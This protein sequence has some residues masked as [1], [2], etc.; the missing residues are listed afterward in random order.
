MKP[1]VIGTRGSA[2]ARWQAEHVAEQLR[3]RHDG[4]HVELCII[5]TRGDNVLDVPLARVGGKGLFVKEIEQALLAG[6][7][8][9]AVHSVKDLPTEGVEG[10]ELSAIERREDPRDVLV[11]RSGLLAELP[12]HARV[13]TSSLRRRCQLLHIRSDLVIR[14]LRGNVNTRLRK[15]DEGLFD[16]VVL[17]AAGLLRLKRADQITEFLEPERMIPA[18]GQGALG[19][20]TRSDDKEIHQ[21]VAD[22][23]HE[24]TAVRVRAERALL[25]RLGGGCQVPIAGHARI[26]GQSL[27]LDGLVGHPAGSPVYRHRAR[28]EA[29][30]PEA[31]GEAVAEHLL[32]QGG[33]RILADVYG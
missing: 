21:T 23:H 3:E 22:L 1:V 32:S 30:A 25:G 6:E 18:V 26:E 20:Q 27:V 7:V 24:P 28:G 13:G 4:L 14:D 10:L 29:S 11:S 31:L 15:L 8:D 17:A 9:L 19:I 16:A 33:D 2:L 12:E 5:K